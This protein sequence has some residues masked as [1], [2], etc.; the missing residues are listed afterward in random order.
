[1]LRTCGLLLALLACISKSSA[2][3]A[4]ACMLA[5]WP[6]LQTAGTCTGNERGLHCTPF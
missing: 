2:A 1:M 3:V 6:E 5:A 4:Y